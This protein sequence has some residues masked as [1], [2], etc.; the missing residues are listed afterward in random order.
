MKSQGNL[1][2][3]SETVK[4]ETSLV[5]QWLRLCAPTAGGLGL[6]PGQRTRPHMSQLRV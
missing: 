4:G 3:G 6:V 2:E 5:V 1:E